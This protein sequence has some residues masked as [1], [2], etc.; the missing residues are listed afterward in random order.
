MRVGGHGIAAAARRARRRSPTARRRRRGPPATSPAASMISTYAGSSL[1]R[2]DAV[3]RLVHRAADRRLGGI[4]LTLGQPQLRQAGL[5]LPSP[6][7]G[8]AVRLLGL[9]ELAAQPVEL[10]LLVEGRTDR[11]L[12][13]RLERPLAAPAAP[14]PWRPARR[15]AAA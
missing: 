11:G 15:R 13:G 7:A 1:D 14:R 4:D 6:L 10:G 8:L 5:R 9:G 2:V 3:L 12:A